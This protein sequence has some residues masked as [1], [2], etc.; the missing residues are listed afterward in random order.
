[1]ILPNINCWASSCSTENAPE[2]WRS[3]VL[4]I[5]IS[6]PPTVLREAM[7]EKRIPG[8]P[9]YS[10]IKFTPPTEGMPVISIPHELCPSS[11]HI[12]Y[13]MCGKEI[14]KFLSQVLRI[15]GIGMVYLC[16]HIIQFTLIYSKSRFPLCVCLSLFLCLSLYVY[17]CAC[18]RVKRAREQA[19]AK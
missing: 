9:P 11:R 6:C 17:V 13:K 18:A 10:E 8:V 2:G 1:M 4:T 14:L 15:S 19:H 7:K 12:D 16:F 5:P 3:E